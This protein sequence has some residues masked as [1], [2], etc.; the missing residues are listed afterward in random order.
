[1]GIRINRTLLGEVAD[2]RLVPPS[3]GFERDLRLPGDRK[4]RLV[5]FG[6]GHTESDTLLHLPDD[7]TLFAGDVVVAGTHPNFA[8]GDPD[9]WLEVLEEIEALRPERLVPGHGPVGTLEYVEEMR[10]YLLSLKDLAERA[11][12]PEI[13]ERFR[14]WSEP[15]QFS[16][17]LEFLRKRR[18]S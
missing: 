13:P 5:T 7:G 4:A 1:M 18:S 11:V 3:K 15:G 14:A 2:L 16:R 6:A 12:K 9:H 10:E 8:S 17:N